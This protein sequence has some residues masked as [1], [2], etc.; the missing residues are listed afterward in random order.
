MG[1]IRSMLLAGAA[2]PV[3]AAGQAQAQSAPA[4]APELDEI[5][6]TAQK[7]VERAIDVPMSLTAVAARDLERQNL[8]QMR[9]YFTRIPG[10][11]LNGRNSGVTT[12]AIRGLT[13][14]YGSNPTVGVTIDDVPYGSASSAGYGDQLT[15]DL[16][17]SDLDRIEVLKGPQ[18]TLYGAS[19]LGGLLK[20]VTTDPNTHEFSGRVQAEAST[21]AHGGEGYAARGAVNI[22]LID[23]QL[24]VRVSGFYRHDPGYIENVLTGESDTN[25][26][27]AEGGRIALLWKP[28]SFIQVKL[29]ALLQNSRGNDSGTV[30]TDFA[31]KPQFGPYQHSRIAGAD[32]YTGKVRFYSGTVSGDLG[33][34]TLTSLSG[35][36]VNDYAG[37]TDVTST[38]QRF[39]ANPAAGISFA[40]RFRTKRFSE[41]VRLASNGKQTVDWLIGGFFTSE[42]S[43][44]RQTFNEVTPQT[45]AFQTLLGN[46]K[47]PYRY[48]EFAGFG[49]LT[50]HVGERLSLQVGGRYAE[51]RQRYDEQGNGPL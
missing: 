16:D 6:V 49:D 43:L 15:A 10:L 30:D 50:L 24:A 40:S 5:V 18:G 41:E 29:N 26:G 35:Y 12:L 45:S 17:P 2:V 9:D 47:Y 20:Y 42:R 22:P 39:A 51:N 44:G 48:R 8:V 11:N 19:A 38:F 23:D 46:Y 33:G 3:L 25:D 27:H 14:G 21:I 28:S 1:V 7:R 13:T 37:F 36:A 31:L 34:A 32:S 4:T